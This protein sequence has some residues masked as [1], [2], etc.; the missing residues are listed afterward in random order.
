MQNGEHI[1]CK[2]SSI[3]IFF[4]LKRLP[5]WWINL[6]YKHSFKHYYY[7]SFR[8]VVKTPHPH[9]MTPISY[10]SHTV[11]ITIHD[12]VKTVFLYINLAPSRTSKICLYTSLWCGSIMTTN[13]GCKALSWLCPAMNY[14]PLYPA[15][16]S[17][18]TLWSAAVIYPDKSCLRFAAVANKTLPLHFLNLRLNLQCSVTDS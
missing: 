6:P 17:P 12:S 7:I 2:W 8:P 3:C 4:I 13:Y 15:P 1:R 18:L 14:H 16:R 11:Q 10:Y 9:D 5:S